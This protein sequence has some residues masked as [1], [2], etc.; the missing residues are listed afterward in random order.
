MK[1]SL[2]FNLLLFFAPLKK[3]IP[4]S[5]YDIKVAAFK[6]GEIDMAAYK[7]KKIL[8]VNAPC[9]SPYDPQY[10]ELEALSKKYSGKLVV[11]ALL[12]DDFNIAPGSKQG[13]DYH[14]TNYKVSF[15]LG[16]KVS[17]RSPDMSPLFQ[18]LTEK[19][20]NNFKD[21]HVKWN[22]QKYLVNEKGD[23]VAVFDPKIKPLSQQVTDAI[24]K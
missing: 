4:A 18:W 23:L 10:R 6:G 7:G 1:L 17:V 22:F 21:S 8:V 3:E 5:I 24:E 2:L 11:V 12:A 16:E 14:K 15:P 19:K 20:Y 9:M 13:G